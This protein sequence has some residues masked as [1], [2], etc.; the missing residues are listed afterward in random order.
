MFEDVLGT[1]RGR[2]WAVPGR[3]WGSLGPPKNALGV[4]RAR[5]W[6][7]RA[8]PGR[9]PGR[10]RSDLGRPER[11]KS[12]FGVILARFRLDL[13]SILIVSERVFVY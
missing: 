6:A 3:S 9:V 12:D 10:P 5:L 2:S 7:S 1:S 13:G 4:S 8:R 11:P